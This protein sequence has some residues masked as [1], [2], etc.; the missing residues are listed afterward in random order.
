MAFFAGGGDVGN[1]AF[2]DITDSVGV[3]EGFFET[4][5][6]E[7]DVVVLGC[8]FDLLF[9]L[10][11]AFGEDDILDPFALTELFFEGGVIFVEEVGFGAREAVES[12]FEDDAGALILFEFGFVSGVCQLLVLRERRGYTWHRQ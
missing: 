2:V 6:I 5:V 3:A 8:L 11:P 10:D 1:G 12:I 7:P 9:V 4:C